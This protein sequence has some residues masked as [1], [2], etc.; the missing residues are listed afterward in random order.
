M[1]ALL[2]NLKMKIAIQNKLINDLKCQNAKLSKKDEKLKKFKKFI[3]NFMFEEEA[4]EKERE[5]ERLFN[6]SDR[7]NE[8][9]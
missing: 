2:E 4:R 6:E 8:K 3:D 5:A 7:R 1:E 9:K